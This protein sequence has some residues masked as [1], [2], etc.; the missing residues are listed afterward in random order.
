MSEKSLR[1]RST[2][3]E[4]QEAFIRAVKVVKGSSVKLTLLNVAKRSALY[5]PEN[6]ITLLKVLKAMTPEE[7][8]SIGL[9]EESLAKSS[10]APDIR[11]SKVMHWNVARSTKRHTHD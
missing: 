4:I 11:P 2:P 1:P 7:L 3:E 5:V 9:A 8:S 10:I 6:E